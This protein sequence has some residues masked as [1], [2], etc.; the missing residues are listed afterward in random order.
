LRYIDKSQLRRTLNLADV[1]NLNTAHSH[2]ATLNAIQRKKYINDNSD[3]WTAIKSNLWNLGHLKCWYSEAKLQQGQGEI[4]HYRPKNKVAKANHPGYW[5]RAFDFKNYRFAHPTVNKRVTDYLSGELAGKGTYFPLRNEA[6]R[7]TNEASE[8]SEEP[9]LLDPC[10]PND[11]DLI[12]YDSDSGKPIPRYK[13]EENEWLYNRAAT[14]I[15]F[16]HLDE[17]TWN[18]ERQD[19]MDDVATLSERILV[20]YAN[21]PYSQKYRDLRGELLEYLS[22]YSE[23][24][25]AAMQ[26][27]KEKGVLGGV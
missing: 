19:L 9:V 4:E 16:Y 18:A 20:E 25:S 27:A 17:G 15:A 10:K 1:T 7:A 2:I 24:T 26:V 13:K 3:K 11:C 21:D 14:S 8:L 6:N 12:C 23:F 5:W 22:E